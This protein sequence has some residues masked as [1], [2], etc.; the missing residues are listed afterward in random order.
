MNKPNDFA[1]SLTKY[2]TSYLSVTVGASKNTIISYR[3]TFKLLLIYASK[4]KSKKPEKLVLADLDRE[5][6]SDFLDWIEDER[7]CSIQT[8][9]QRLT[10]VHAFCKYLQIEH[11]EYMLVFQKIIAIPKKK[12]NQ[13]V[14][15]FLSIEGIELLLQQPDCSSESGKKHM[16]LLTFMYASA[17]RVQEAVDAVIEDY[18]F[19]GTNLMKLTGKGK[20]SRL[21]PLEKSVV[22]LMD[23]YIENCKKNKLFSEKN[24][25]FLNHSNQK[26]SRQGVT[27]I[28]KKYADMAREKRP[29]LIPKD[30]SPHTLRHS[31][32]VHWL[33]AGVELIYIRDL[34]G[35][36]SVQTTEVYAKIDGDMKRKALERLSGI[37]NM[38]LPEWQ[39][40]QDLMVWLKS[41]GS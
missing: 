19:N 29:D 21:V 18:K 27:S 40:N 35:H 2:L 15:S 24:L 23:N 39:K 37:Q 16:M 25:L 6:I 33:Q 1:Y 41:L 12:C 3:D 17:C 28:I 30:I 7:G 20:K 32:A 13:K 11:P 26:L 9:N 14:V 10:A 31:R 8:R 36:V 38:N 22:K 5:F 4:Q 34:L